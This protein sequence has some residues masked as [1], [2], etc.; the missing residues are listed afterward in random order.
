M[1]KRARKRQEKG[2]QWRVEERQPSD[3]RYRCENLTRKPIIRMPRE[4]KVA[5]YISNGTKSYTEF[6]KYT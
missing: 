4:A 1:I 5:I 6:T 3:G 2:G